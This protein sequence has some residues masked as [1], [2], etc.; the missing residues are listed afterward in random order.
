[1]ILTNKQIY[2]YA[3]KLV[4]FHTEQKMPVK[5]NF[6]LQKNIQKIIE[7][8]KEIEFAKD[9]IIKSYGELNAD[10]SGY[11]ISQEQLP[12]ANKDLNELFNL[13]QDLNLYIFKLDDFNNLELTMEQLSAIM[14]MI[15]E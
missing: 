8:V 7:A 9:E 12:A 4:A 6:F 1:M 14:F 2:E 3:T 15:E 5:I 13:E 10:E 11:I